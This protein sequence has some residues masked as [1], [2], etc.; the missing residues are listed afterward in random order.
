MEATCCGLTEAANYNDK[1]II[2]NK[3]SLRSRIVV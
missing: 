1:V 3:P 2:Q